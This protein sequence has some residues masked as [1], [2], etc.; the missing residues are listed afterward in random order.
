[1]GIPLIAILLALAGWKG[2]QQRPCIPWEC[3]SLLTSFLCVCR[4]RRALPR[5]C[6]RGQ[7]IGG[8][9]TRQQQDGGELHHAST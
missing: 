8:D 6:P 4:A 1:M 9:Q 7:V 3:R 5:S 2:G